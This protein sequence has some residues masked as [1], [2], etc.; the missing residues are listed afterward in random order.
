MARTLGTQRWHQK[1]AELKVGRTEPP[2]PHHTTPHH[3]ILTDQQAMAGKK[4]STQAKGKRKQEQGTHAKGKGKAEEEV[5]VGA[6]GVVRG[7]MEDIDV[8][9][10]ESDSPSQEDTPPTSPTRYETH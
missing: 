2:Q 9:G 4:R 1:Q 6:G 3:H 8:S 5:E 7:S 10:E